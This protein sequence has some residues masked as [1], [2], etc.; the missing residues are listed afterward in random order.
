MCVE[1]H[2]MVTRILIIMN[3]HLILL[4]SCTT[5]V[6]WFLMISCTKAQQQYS[7]NSVLTCNNSEETAGA[8]PSSAFL[9]SC[10]GEHTSCR[11][12]LIF[13]ALF[14]YVSVPMISTLTSSDQSE[15]ARLNNVT[16]LTVFPQGTEVIVPVNCSCSASAGKYYQATAKYGI[17][18]STDTFFTIAN[19]TY[20]GLST[21]DSLKKFRLDSEESELEVPLRCACP[22][23][24]QA[25]DGIHYLITY[26]V[27]WN[28]DVSLISKSFNV[29]RKT[30]T[31][32]NG[33]LDL[34][35]EDPTIFPFTTILIP[36]PNEPLSRV[37]FTPKNYPNPNQTS[38]VLSLRRSRRNLPIGGLIAAG[39]SCLLLFVAILFIFKTKRMRICGIQ[40][41]GTAH[42]GEGYSSD[43]H[44]EIASI[45]RFIRIYKYQELRKATGNFCSKSR[46]EG[47][48]YRGV[49]HKGKEIIAIKKM[50]TEPAAY[51]EVN[52][53]SR[54]NHFNLIKL[55]GYCEHRHHQ[56]DQFLFFLVFE[57]MKNGSLRQWLH[58]RKETKMIRNGERGWFQRIQI[59][60]DIANGLLYLHNFAKPAYVHK[61]INSSNILL[62]SNLRAKISNFGFA[63]TSSNTVT[64]RV[65]G[66]KGYMA[67]EYIKTGLVTQKIDVYAFGVVLLELITSKDAVAVQ[68]GR[69]ILLSTEIAE[70]VGEN[71]VDGLRNLVEPDLGEDGKMEYAFQI[72]HLSLCC[73]MQ[74]P[75]N[76]PSMDDVVSNLIKIQSNMQKSDCPEK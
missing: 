53:L 4:F 72:V 61:D 17:H 71:G 76:R 67:P 20:Q 34:E 23:K 16:I 11:A 41:K 47:C 33:F 51:N 74:N 63:R 48:V 65:V 8:P 15:I 64:R 21:C 5:I 18:K 10:N 42:D 66:T 49:L 9:Y 36:L 22:T 26:T 62:D 31:D 55:L 44:V 29:C 13:R 39:F 35:E 69:D 32:A 50:S 45:D 73:L 59:A 37:N 2:S 60:L 58:S 3:F 57:Y 7:G 43:I 52:M 24:R 30:V 14:P 6:L 75:V 56:S 19:N 27:T 46:I 68:D 70:M 1:Q 12:F 54:M 28:D 25:A 38:Y 40:G